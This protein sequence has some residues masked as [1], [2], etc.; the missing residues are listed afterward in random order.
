MVRSSNRPGQLLGMPAMTEVSVSPY[1]THVCAQPTHNNATDAGGSHGLNPLTAS[2]VSAK[3]TARRV[4]KADPEG[5]MPHPVASTE[6]VS[7]GRPECPAIPDPHDSFIEACIRA[8][9]AELTRVEC[10]MML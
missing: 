4:P 1:P 7:A 10:K 6:K 8:R 5:M 3:A 2:E 9:E